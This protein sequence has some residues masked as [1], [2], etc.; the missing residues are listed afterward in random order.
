MTSSDLIFAYSYW[1]PRDISFRKRQLNVFFLLHNQVDTENSHRIHCTHMPKNQVTSSLRHHD[2]IGIKM[3][4]TEQTSLIESASVTS[5]LATNWKAVYEKLTASELNAG[6]ISV[7]T[8]TSV[9]WFSITEY[10]WSEFASLTTQSKNILK[11]LSIITR[12]NLAEN[13]LSRKSL[14]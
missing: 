12:F 4:L 3:G 14:K 1:W 5:E 11:N 13:R 6:D 7:L 8:N 2:V 10:S 9:H